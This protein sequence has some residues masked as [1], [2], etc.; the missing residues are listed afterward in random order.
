MMAAREVGAADA[1]RKQHIADKAPAGWRRMKHH[2]ARR[3]AGAVPHRERLLA[4]G[5]GVAIFQPPG[6]SERLCRREAEH[7]GL[8]RQA[9]DPEQISL[10]R[11]DD[12]QS[13]F[14][15]PLAGTAGMVDVCMRQPDG[16]DRHAQRLRHRLEPRDFTAR[17]DHRRVLGD[18]AP[19]DAAV[20]LEGG[21]G[22]GAVLEG[23]D[24]GV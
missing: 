22:D 1:A 12:R 7:G 16:L 13:V 23:H 18:V 4:D 10:V 3:V 21:D 5:D 24:P 17:V 8:L 20:L 9:G 19:D 6:R 15:R 11:P 2:V 14:P